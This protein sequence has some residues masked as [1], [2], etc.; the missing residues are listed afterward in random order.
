LY[1]SRF[2]P[3]DDTIKDVW[4]YNS[5]GVRQPQLTLKTDPNFAPSGIA[6]DAAGRIWVAERTNNDIQIGQIQIFQNQAVV[7]TITNGLVYPLGIAFAKNGGK[8]YVGDAESPDDM[9]TI[10]SQ[11]GQEIS[12]I[13]T[14]DCAPGYLAFSASGNL[15]VPC[16]VASNELVVFSPAGKLI[17][18]ITDGLD[19]P[20]G[21]AFDSAGNFFVSNAANSTIT[22]Y[23]PAGKLIRTIQ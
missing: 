9:I 16:S 8:A 13:S 3:N 5:Q 19:Y 7:D 20:I 12:T 11:S 18:T 15:Y 21:L 10:F 4:V 1:V 22:E 6:F 17:K 23:T 14:P 2:D